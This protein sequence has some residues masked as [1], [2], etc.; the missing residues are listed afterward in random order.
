[1][2]TTTMII[3]AALIVAGGLATYKYVVKAGQPSSPALDRL[4]AQKSDSLLNA[5]NSMDS[6]EKQVFDLYAVQGNNAQT[7]IDLA[8]ADKAL[9]SNVLAMKVRRPYSSSTIDPREI[10]GSAL[11]SSFSQK[12]AAL[13]PAPQIAPAQP[14]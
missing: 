11:L 5:W 10:V 12:R 8:S 7:A 13:A 3:G 6:E 4:Q 1:M 2:K 14:V 9:V